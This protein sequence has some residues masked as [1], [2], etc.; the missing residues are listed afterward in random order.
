MPS[1]VETVIDGLE[2]TILKPSGTNNLRAIHFIDE[3]IGFASGYDGKLIMTSDGGTTWLVKDTKTTVPLLSI[4][5][6]DNKKGFVV[7]E[8]SVMLKTTDGGTS[9]NKVSLNLSEKIE[10]NA[11]KFVNDTIG[12]AIGNYTILK[13]IDAGETWDSTNISNLNGDMREIDFNG[14]QFGL[15]ICTFGQII[16]TSDWGESWNI[17]SSI[18]ENGTTSI[19]ITND[20]TVYAS[21]NTKILKSTDLGQTWIELAA[22]PSDNFSINFISNDIGLA[23]GRGNYS[24]GCF[25]YS[26]GSLFY[27]KDQGKNWIGSKDIHETNSYHEC[28]FP[29]MDLGYIVSSDKI[30]KVKIK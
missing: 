25:G 1:V 10:L 29:S 23:V 24:G 30:L 21:G 14:T 11:I 16:S 5:F 13:T 8:E 19:S 4:D 9:W 22:S 28:S 18:S 7:G 17:I 2:L 26:Y 15:I 3:N 20:N 12:F 27:T 6:I